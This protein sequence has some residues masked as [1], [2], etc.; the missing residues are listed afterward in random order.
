MGNWNDTANYNSGFAD[1][2]AELMPLLLKLEWSGQRRGPGSGPMFSGGDGHL[3]PVCPLCGGLKEANRDFNDDA[4]GHRPDC[5]F[6]SLKR[7]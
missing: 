6:M 4:V 3:W 7:A 1:G 2:R 5:E